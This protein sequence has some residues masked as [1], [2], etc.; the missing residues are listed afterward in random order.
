MWRAL[1]GSFVA[2]FSSITRQTEISYRLNAIRLEDL[3]S[4]EKHDYM[5]L[6]KL[7]QRIGQLTSTAQIK[8][9]YD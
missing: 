9:R 4:E 7:T 8:D 6:E 5:A 2:R 1:C 3:I